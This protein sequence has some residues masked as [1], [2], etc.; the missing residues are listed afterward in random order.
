MGKKLLFSVLILVSLFLISC[1][2][3]KT[4]GFNRSDLVGSWALVTYGV[5]DFFELHEDGTGTNVGFIRNHQLK[6][7][8][9]ND[10]LYVNFYY[11]NEFQEQDKY[12]IDSLNI[13][14]HDNVKYN[15]LYLS[16]IE[17]VYQGYSSMTLRDHK[18]ILDFMTEWLKTK[19][20]REWLADREKKGEQQWNTY[21][22]DW[23]YSEIGEIWLNS[24]DGK[25]WLQTAE[26]KEFMRTELREYKWA[27]QIE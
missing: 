2:K 11:D 1:Q 13:E 7:N 14:E 10:S 24:E 5:E 18:Q 16:R 22:N 27:K 26:G 25:A 3:Q 17:R 19:W 15:V 4:S 23:L 20:G 21:A 9:E 8:V 12:S 6:W